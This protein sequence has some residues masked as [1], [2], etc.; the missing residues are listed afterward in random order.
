V[1]NRIE[2]HIEKAVV[3]LAVEKPAYGQVR[4]ATIWPNAGC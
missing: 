2:E 3:E 4:A 1:K